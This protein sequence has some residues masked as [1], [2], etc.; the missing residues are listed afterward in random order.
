MYKFI[1]T[2]SGCCGGSYDVG[3]AEANAN[4][5]S[6]EGFD[7]VQVYQSST[8]GCGGAQ[9]VLVMVFKKR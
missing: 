5:M 1:V 6:K 4:K 2:Q 7:L 9:S 3:K 8:A